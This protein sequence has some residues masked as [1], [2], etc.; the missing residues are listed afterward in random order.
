MHSV[1]TAAIMLD[2]SPRTVQKWC[3][4]LGFKK[5]SSVYIL[6]DAQLDL[7]ERQN[8]QPGRPRGT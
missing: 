2:M 6:T 7:I 5:T 1:A 3:K 4:R 8:H